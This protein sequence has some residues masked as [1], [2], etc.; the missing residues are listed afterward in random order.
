MDSNTSNP[1]CEIC[2]KENHIYIT[3]LGI[4]I[5]HFCWNS[6]NTLKN[7]FY[8]WGVDLDKIN[9]KIFLGNEAGQNKKQILKVLGI[10]NILVVGSELQIFHSSD[11]IYKKI[12]IEDFYSEN[13]AQHFN[14]CYDFI[15]KSKGNVYIH[16]AAGISRS[17]T[18]VIAYL[19]RKNRKKFSETF[20]FVKS[21][22]KY[23][24]PNE[25]F[26]NQLKEYEKILKIMPKI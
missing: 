5:C 2:S 12:E 4:R 8:S 9:E 21:R 15:E 19:M 3:K 11:F 13:I 25:G 18:I 24:N 7:R 1:I 23:V 20:E 17:P 16:C 10:T 6:P 26:I 22:R 14:D